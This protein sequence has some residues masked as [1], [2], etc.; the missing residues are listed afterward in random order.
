M[1]E[2]G[3]VIGTGVPLHVAETEVAVVCQR[4]WLGQHARCPERAVS[5]HA[6][7]QMRT[8]SPPPSSP[9]RWIPV[10]EGLGR[11]HPRRGI[12]IRSQSYS[13]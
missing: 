12:Q 6:S 7:E 3:Y 9:H 13:M 11:A 2:F 1:H 4:P 8:P 5:L 10:G